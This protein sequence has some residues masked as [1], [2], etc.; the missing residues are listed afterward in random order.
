MDFS[1]RSTQIFFGVAGLLIVL[2]VGVGCWRYRVYWVG[3]ERRL[4]EGRIAAGAAVAAARR[5]R[6]LNAGQSDDD[7]NRTLDRRHLLMSMNR[8][9]EETAV[10]SDYN[11]QG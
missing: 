10:A 4:E 8:R 9:P 1:D 7:E 5:E 2:I 3:E 11:N 6:W